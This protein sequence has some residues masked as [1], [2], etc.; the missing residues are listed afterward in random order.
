MHSSIHT[1]TSLCLCVCDFRLLNQEDQIKLCTDNRIYSLQSEVPYLADVKGIIAL[2][3]LSEKGNIA[4]A[5]FIRCR[6]TLS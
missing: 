4:V 1:A 5:C 3:F 6:H 2:E